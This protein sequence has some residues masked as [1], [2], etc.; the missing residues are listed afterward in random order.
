MNPEAGISYGQNAAAAARFNPK[1]MFFYVRAQ[2]ECGAQVEV[3]QRQRGLP[4]EFIV[5]PKA[6][7]QVS[8]F[9][10]IVDGQI[11][12]NMIEESALGMYQLLDLL[13]HP[14]RRRKKILGL[15]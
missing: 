11:R 3:M 5:T 13:I 4:W 8:D 14:V 9:A 1:E 12:I 10:R 6:G 2:L 7:T 15:F